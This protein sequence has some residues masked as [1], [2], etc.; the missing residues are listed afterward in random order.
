M[1]KTVEKPAVYFTGRHYFCLQRLY[2]Y[3]HSP[4]HKRS[5]PLL[6]DMQKYNTSM[7]DCFLAYSSP[8]D[9]NLAD[10]ILK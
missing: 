4:E 10:Y 8:I 7:D 9:A 1:L 3:K 2:P 6:T 5:V